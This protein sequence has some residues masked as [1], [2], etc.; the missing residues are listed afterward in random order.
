VL[1]LLGAS[2]GWIDRQIK[3]GPQNR[4]SSQFCGSSGDIDVGNLQSHV[5]GRIGI[6]PSTEGFLRIRHIIPGPTPNLFSCFLPGKVFP[7]QLFTI[8]VKSHRD[9][10]YVDKGAVGV[11]STLSRGWNKSNS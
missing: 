4:N 8:A 10:P 3:I 11:L 6:R 5:I 1:G 2:T 7:H 9:K